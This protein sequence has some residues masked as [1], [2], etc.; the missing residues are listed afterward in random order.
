MP[1]YTNP[2]KRIDLEQCSYADERIF[3]LILNTKVFFHLTNR[4]KGFRAGGKIL[5][6]KSDFVFRMNWDQTVSWGAAF[7]KDAEADLVLR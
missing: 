6:A 2:R 5:K 7:K 1:E 4:G 3:S